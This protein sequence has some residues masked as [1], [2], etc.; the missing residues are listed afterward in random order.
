MASTSKVNLDA[1]HIF[2]RLLATE[3]IW[4]Q[5]KQVS[6]AS[7]DLVNRVLTFPIWKDM[8]DT[9][10]TMLAAHEVGH[11]LYSPKMSL[12]DIG[13]LI[14]PK[15]ALL[16]GQYWNVVEDVRIEKL[17]KETYPGL[18][19]SFIEAYR[20]LYE[21]GFFG[22]DN[23][24]LSTLGFIDRINLHY[25]IGS[26]ISLSFT[27]LE[28]AFLSKIDAAL[29]N[30]DA[31]EVARQIYE[32]A[33]HEQNEPP[34]TIQDF[35]DMLKEQ[36]DCDIDFGFSE[37][38]EG[39]DFDEAGVDTNGEGESDESEGDS[40]DGASGESDDESDADGEDQEKPKDKGKGK[41]TEKKDD[42]DSGGDDSGTADSS[43]GGSDSKSDGE[44]EAPVAD[45]PKQ[46]KKPKNGQSSTGKKFG[47]SEPPK[48]PTAPI[49]Q[50]A[51]DEKLEDLNDKN[52]PDIEYVTLPKPIM[53]NVVV[54]HK[55]VHQGIRRFNFLK[56]HE[57]QRNSWRRSTT[58]ARK[59]KTNEEYF[60]TAEKHY[61]E[62]F[63][64]NKPKVDYIFQQFM[65]FKQAQRYKR[66]RQHKTG[67]LDPLR[68][69]AYKIDEDLFKSIAIVADDKNHALLFVVDWSGSMQTSMAGTLEQLM[70]LCMFCRRGG[71]PFRVMSLTIGGGK[72]FEQK[73]GN[74][75][76]TDNFQMRC[77]LSSEMT[78]REFREACINLFALMIDG[79]FHG[80]PAKDS[81][82]GCT[83]LNEAIITS[84]E[85]IREMK[86]KADVV[87]AIFLTDGDANTV[88]GFVDKNGKSRSLDYRTKY[89][90]DDREHHKVYEFDLHHMTPT[91]FQILRDFQDINVV[92][93]YIN[94]RWQG[95]FY[96]VDDAE[97]K[98]LQT[99]FDTDGY[100]IC[101]TWGYNELYITKVG[102]QWR[103]KET[104]IT[105]TGEELGTPEYMEALTKNFITQR[106][107]TRKQRV[108]LDRFV[109][110]IA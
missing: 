12:V 56:F 6:T 45:K 64:F 96:D 14:D 23:R 93:F 70:M 8:S 36:G 81:L 34:Q 46:E 88:N 104:P 18:L 87:N 75:T 107:N 35:L 72:A 103:I 61:D 22:T 102:D 57:D 60:A 67:A 100:V 20:D 2:A 13:A 38:G 98:K 59:E 58:P 30:D 85:M 25:K 7:F 26:H 90:I 76:F 9:L 82:T 84:I 99:Q 32:Y 44:K 89:V 105:P 55:E 31:I 109:K 16:A 10:Y 48:T 110:M 54:G 73:P 15:N 40:E 97:R 42:S 53:K 68:M 74:L 92:G 62:F 11:A 27:P 78:S 95:F 108:M 77:Y 106:K 1:K 71:I 69:W 47:N 83:P 41:K 21:R 49:T 51:Y 101:T 19:R 39:D 37:D 24:D 63:R 66:T 80:G 29:T 94:G 33:K 86:S 50:Q 3:N 43:S 17:V 4:I 91:M 79:T 52:A 65:M 5:H 28:R